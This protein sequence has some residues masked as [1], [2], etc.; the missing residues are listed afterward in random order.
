[1]L[2]QNPLV[3]SLAWDNIAKIFS[4][5]VMGGYVPLTIL[6]F[7]VE[8]RLF[9]LDPFIYHLDNLLLHLTVT[10]LVYHL[11]RCLKLDVYAAGLAAVVFGLH[12]MRVESVAWVTERKD[13]LCAV[14]YLMAMRAH[15]SFVAEGHRRRF[16]FLTLLLGFLSILAKPMALS[17]PL[18]LL[19][20]DRMLD[21]KWTLSSVM[22]KVPYLFYIIPVVGVTYAASHSQIPP[23]I[24]GESVLTVI[25][26][27]AFYIG[28]F[29][30]PFD[31]SPLYTVVRPVSLHHPLY[32]AALLFLIV[33]IALVICFR[34]NRWVLFAMFFY[35]LSLWFLFRVVSFK[36]NVVADRYL[37]IP[38]IGFCWLTGYVIC[39]AWIRWH[40][41]KW[42]RVA[43]VLGVSV[44]LTALAAKCFAQC[45]I[46][47][48]N[49]TLFSAMIRYDAGNGFALYNRA[50][51]YESRREFELALR[52]YSQAIVHRPDYAKA[53][54]NRAAINLVLGR[55][56]EALA[57]LNRVIE[58]EPNLAEA[59][60]NR[61]VIYLKRNQI[62]LARSDLIKAL[63][64]DPRLRNARRRL[65][66]LEHDE[67]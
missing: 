22:E 32:A 28:K 54:N 45:R 16:Y 40:A 34:R 66:Q 30:Y 59:Y 11:G 31:L 43:L 47:K 17:L 49:V 5:T 35:L 25:W 15:V 64:I 12:P 39:G 52:D 23:L 57:D 2:T 4:S 56:E 36:M 60:S 50:K 10:A 14:F 67:P 62:D 20:L 18:I 51:A 46:W 63:E 53:Y 41:Q 48:D 44:M 6:S 38:G 3:R 7:A 27:A 26:C 24:P 37:Y 9:G 1:M 8:H 13:L 65:D 21:R 19:L 29:L 33:V 42:A 61:S 58:L 55:D